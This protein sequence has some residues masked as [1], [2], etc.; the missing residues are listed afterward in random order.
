ML[1][2][3]NGDEL[4]DMT[5]ALTLGN[6]TVPIEQTIVTETATAFTQFSIGPVE[7]DVLSRSD[8]LQF[9]YVAKTSAYEARLL[10]PAVAI[11][12]EIA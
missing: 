10:A 11:L 3:N 2:A 12:G 4:V 1:A 6:S 9:Q 7:F 5:T 8:P